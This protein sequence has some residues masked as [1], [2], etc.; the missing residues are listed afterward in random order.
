MPKMSGRLLSEQL[1]RIPFFLFFIGVNMAFFP[2]HQLGL[3]G[4][5][6]RTFHYPQSPEWASLNLVSTIGAYIIGI[7]IAVFP[8]TFPYSTL[9]PHARPPRPHPSQAAPP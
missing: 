2:M 9:P 8:F 6:R 4:M 7:S 1:G 3:D 5:P